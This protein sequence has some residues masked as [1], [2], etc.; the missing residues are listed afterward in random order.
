MIDLKVKNNDINNDNS[1]SYGKKNL[2]AKTHNKNNNYDVLYETEN[3]NSNNDIPEII[4]KDSK[5]YKNKIM[6][7]FNKLSIFYFILCYIL[8]FIFYIL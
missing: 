4:V 1:P 3:T 2:N 5:Y 6:N 7:L 8:Y